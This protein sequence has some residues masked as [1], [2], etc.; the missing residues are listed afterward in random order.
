MR[1]QGSTFLQT[2]TSDGKQSGTK[3]DASV[4]TASFNSAPFHVGR[5]LGYVVVVSCPSTGTPDG[6]VKLQGSIDLPNGDSDHPDVGV[7]TWFDL[8]LYDE[9]TG[10]AVVSQAVSGASTISFTETDCFYKWFR[11]VWTE[12]SGSIT[13]T[14]KCQFKGIG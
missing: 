8:T 7:A 3:L 9:A 14:A 12:T 10:A 1:L 5:V 2:V 6:T 11:L 4:Q 13:I